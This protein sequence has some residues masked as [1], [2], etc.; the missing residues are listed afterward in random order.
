MMISGGPP[1]ARWHVLASNV[2]SH[3]P[4]PA[5]PA[6]CCASMPRDWHHLL[7]CQA[8]AR[9]ADPHFRLAY[10]VGGTGCRQVMM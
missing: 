3:G 4:A 2:W 8:V 6:P 5:R 10:K 1:A 9:S 7:L